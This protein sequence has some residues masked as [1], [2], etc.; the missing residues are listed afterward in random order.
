MTV[1]VND[2][3]NNVEILLNDTANDRWSAAELLV[4]LNIGQRDIVIRTLSLKQFPAYVKME[5]IL[6]DEGSLQDLRTLVSGGLKVLDVTRNMG[7][8]WAANTVYNVDDA[9]YSNSTRYVCTTSHTSS[10][11]TFAVDVANW[12]AS[13]QIKSGVPIEEYN[14]DNLDDI[15]PGWI[16]ADARDEADVSY[17]VRAENDQKRF[18]VVPQQGATQRQYVE[19]TYAALPA[20]AVAGGNLVIADEYQDALMDFILYKAHSKDEDV[21]PDTISMSVMYK[22]LYDTNPVFSL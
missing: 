19:L 5:P 20:N 3:I 13:K 7:R 10:S 18:Y 16:S 2:I 12:S 8:L 17:W 14:K 1:A 22:Q 9:V 6:L 4:Y 11:S 15:M 21:A